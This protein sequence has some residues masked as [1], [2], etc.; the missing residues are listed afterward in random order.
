MFRQFLLLIV[1][2]LLIA[3]SGSVGDAGRLMP[4][5]GDGVTLTQTKTKNVTAQI[6]ADGAT[7]NVGGAWA[8]QSFQR[9]EIEIDNKSVQPFSFD[10]SKV[11]FE[12]DTGEKL[13]LNRVADTTGVDNSD[14][15]PNNDTVKEVYKQDAKP[16]ATVLTVAPNERRTLNLQFNNFTKPENKLTAEKTVVVSLP[17]NESERKIFFNCVVDKIFN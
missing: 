13:I 14:S 1:I 4:Q 10:Y 12:G 11:A 3:C 15:N 16:L 2:G 17:V 8:N 7:L 9:L 5:A 6:A